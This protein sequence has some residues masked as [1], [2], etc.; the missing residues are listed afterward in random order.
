MSLINYIKDLLL[1]PK[2]LEEYHIYANKAVLAIL[3]HFNIKNRE[4][5]ILNCK[6]IVKN[7]HI[8]YKG[9]RTIEHVFPYYPLQYYINNYVPCGCRE[10]SFYTVDEVLDRVNLNKFINDNSDVFSEINRHFIKLVL[11]YFS[12]EELFDLIKL[13]RRTEEFETY[14]K[15]YKENDEVEIGI[16]TMPGVYIKNKTGDL[17]LSIS[18]LSDKYYRISVDLRLLSERQLAIKALLEG[19]GFDDSLARLL[20]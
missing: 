5:P 17:I 15:V 12:I 14:Y 19:K 16:T 13:G 8:Y 10:I 9:I 20:V 18:E 11:K 4:F 6:H 3:K 7:Y 2:S 1:K